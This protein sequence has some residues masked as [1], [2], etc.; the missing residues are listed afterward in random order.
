MKLAEIPGDQRRWMEQWR[1]AAVAIEEIRQRELYHLSEAA[2]LRKSE[3]VLSLPK[4]WRRPGGGNGLVEQ[5]AWFQ[6]WPKS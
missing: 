3:A 5:Q 6:R 4:P 1:E 2:A